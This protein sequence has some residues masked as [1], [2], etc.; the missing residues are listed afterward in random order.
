[1]NRSIA[2]LAIAALLACAE[3]APPATFPG[4]PSGL[5]VS[6]AFDDC[7]PWDGAATTIYLAADSATGVREA[8]Y[9]HLWVSLY[10]PSNDM[11]GRTFHWDQSD[12]DTG[13][14]MWCPEHG[15]CEAATAAEV[16]I[17]QSTE[18]HAGVSGVIDLT[19][20]GRG[21]VTGSFR[22]AWMSHEL[23]CG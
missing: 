9:P 11:A 4:A 17:R 22:A 7:A 6:W 5:E 23:L 3:A 13:G 15:R 10:V 1:M 19:F 8:P 21:R 2:T 14:A 16:S 18:D 20:P 12:K